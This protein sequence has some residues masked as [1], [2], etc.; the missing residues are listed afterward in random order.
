MLVWIKDAPKVQENTYE[1]VEESVDKCITCD[2]QIN[3]QIQFS[4]T[5]NALHCCFITFREEDNEHYT[6]AATDY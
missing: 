4:N 5:T 6:Q 1:E 2:A 3:L